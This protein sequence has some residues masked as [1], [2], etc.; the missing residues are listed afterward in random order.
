MTST[1]PNASIS[2]YPTLVLVPVELSVNRRAALWPPQGALGGLFRHAQ[3]S[4]ENTGDSIDV[5]GARGTVVRGQ[6]A[7]IGAQKFNPCCH[8]VSRS[9]F[10]PRQG[11]P[12]DKRI[13]LFADGSQHLSS[14]R[15]QIADPPRANVV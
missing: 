1:V 9:L 6:T 14:R 3:R 13:V 10:G 12:L 4:N 8:R 15:K 2:R 11:K 7:G 5:G